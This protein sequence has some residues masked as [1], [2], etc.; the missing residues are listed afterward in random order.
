QYTLK[1]YVVLLTQK[2]FHDVDFSVIKDHIP[3]LKETT[4]AQLMAAVKKHK[5]TTPSAWYVSP[6]LTN[7]IPYLCA[8]ESVPDGN[9]NED[10]EEPSS[11]PLRRAEMLKNRRQ[12]VRNI[13]E[14][15]GN[16][17]TVFDMAVRYDERIV[18]EERLIFIKIL[19]SSYST[20]IE[21]GEIEVRG[22]IVYSLIQSIEY[23]EDAASRG[24]P[25]SDWNALQVASDS[26]A[27][28]AES[29]MRRLFNLK[30]RIRH[31][32]YL[33]FDLDFFVVQLR[34]RQILA[35][36]HAHERARRVFKEEFSKAGEDS[37]T[38]AEKIVLDESDAQVEMAE[39]A[40]S[41]LDDDDVAIVKSHYVC[42]ILLNRAAYYFKKLKKHGLMTE[43]EAG[44]HLEE[45]EENIQH[46]LE[47]R[48]T[49]HTD[50]MTTDRKTRRLSALD[51]ELVALNLF[52]S[53]D[54]E[55]KAILSENR[56]NV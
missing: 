4:Y 49:T 52:G 34:V 22:F 31:R 46:I 36:I 54:D 9:D 53:L 23:A 5:K 28:P 19:C 32:K 2:R 44:E 42:Q 7:V 17:Q 16:R 56:G 27:R 45:I 21:H 33:D 38:A 39:Q 26:L 12:S 48:E 1:E 8:R 35:F 10:G 41:T 51:P 3:F 14:S 13:R 40:L 47:C 6:N 30:E 24:L 15:H 20:L 29:I 55:S 25:L 11:R 18:Q 50:E 37:L 43:R